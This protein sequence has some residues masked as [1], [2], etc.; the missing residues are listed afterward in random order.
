[1]TATQRKL[2]LS[3]HT[4]RHLRRERWVTLTH[5]QSVPKLT[6]G[7]IYPIYGERLRARVVSVKGGE[8]CRTYELE[9]AR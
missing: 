5:A 2:I 8:R 3:A 9:A 6:I 4:L 1:M 7:E